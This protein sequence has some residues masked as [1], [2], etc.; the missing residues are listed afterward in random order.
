MD[1]RHCQESGPPCWCLRCCAVPEYP[2]ARKVSETSPPW[3]GC[4]RS[5]PPLQLGR[6]T[7]QC[8]EYV[9]THRRGFSSTTGLPLGRRPGCHDLRRIPQWCYPP[10]PWRP[11]SRADC[12]A[13]H[14]QQGSWRGSAGTCRG[15]PRA[16]A[17]V[18]YP[19][20]SAFSA[21]GGSSSLGQR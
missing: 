7:A 13:C 5:V 21:D 2:P 9:W 3:I 16:Y 14:R 19:A 18:R 6:E 4:C 15:R 17:R 12:R 20:A 11:D 10:G 8:R 1:H